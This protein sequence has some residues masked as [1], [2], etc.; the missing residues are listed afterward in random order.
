MGDRLILPVR[1]ARLGASGYRPVHDEAESVLPGC[2][3]PLEAKL[4]Q[5]SPL[6]WIDCQSRNVDWGSAQKYLG[7]ELA[8]LANR[9]VIASTTGRTTR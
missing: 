3:F 7:I 4:A 2:Q 6:L 5:S 9:Y 8:K 1:G